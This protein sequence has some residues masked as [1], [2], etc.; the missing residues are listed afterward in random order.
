ML[1]ISKH[2]DYYDSLSKTYMDKS[3]VYIRTQENINNKD[4]KLS[5]ELHKLIEIYKTIPATYNYVWNIK[6]YNYIFEPILIGY[7]GL[8]YLVFKYKFDD[9]EGYTHT[10]QD[11]I[12]KYNEMMIYNKNKFLINYN[13][14]EKKIK[15]AYSEIYK[16][17]QDNI[18]IEL[19]CPYFT[20]THNKLSNINHY[21][22]IK[23]PI[24][25]DIEFTKIKDNFTCFQDI[26]TYLN[27]I[28]VVNQNKNIITKINNDDLITKKGFDKKY[29]F[30]IFSKKK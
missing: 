9:I 15:N 2:N 13:F 11:T 29:S 27:S 4:I 18:F 12:K 25:K 1:I 14:N 23:N 10:L 8:F 30:R 26:Q 20:I 21:D 19:N 7:C 5:S 24:L 22:I 16:M 3:I 28:L 17:K 6:G